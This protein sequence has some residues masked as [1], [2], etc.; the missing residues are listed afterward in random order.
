MSWRGVKWFE[1]GIVIWQATRI[2]ALYASSIRLAFLQLH[3]HHPHIIPDISTTTRSNTTPYRQQWL[4]NANVPLQPSL[5]HH[6]TQAPTRQ[7]QHISPTSTTPLSAWK[8]S[9][10]TSLHGPGQHTT[11]QPQHIS[12]AA[13][14]NDIATTGQKRSRFVVCLAGLEL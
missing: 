13:R 12:T 8:A 10:H 5:P 4:S 14:E 7:R 9:S 11:I 2:K 6:Q 1:A 3:L